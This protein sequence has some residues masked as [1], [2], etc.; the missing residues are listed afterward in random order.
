LKKTKNFEGQ[1]VRKKS[2]RLTR[3]AYK[4]VDENLVGSSNNDQEVRGGNSCILPNGKVLK[5][6]YRKEIRMLTDDERKRYFDAVFKLKETG[7]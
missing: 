7:V 6:A 3:Q 2:I 5:K 1:F 4:D